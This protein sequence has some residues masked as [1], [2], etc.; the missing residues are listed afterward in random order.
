MTFGIL[1]QGSVHSRLAYRHFNRY[2]VHSTGTMTAIDVVNRYYDL[3]DYTSRAFGY[4]HATLL[5][6]GLPLLPT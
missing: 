1:S 2:G 4:Q 6:N 3:F 5:N